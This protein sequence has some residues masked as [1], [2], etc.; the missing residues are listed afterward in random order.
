MNA[1]LG[2]V[3]KHYLTNISHYEQQESILGESRICK[4]INCRVVH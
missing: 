1:K 2:Y 4:A 3:T